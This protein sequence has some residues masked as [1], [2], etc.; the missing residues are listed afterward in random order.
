M[1]VVVDAADETRL[2]RLVDA[3]ACRSRTR[4]PGWRPRRP[5]EQRLAVAD[6]RAR[7]RRRPRRLSRRPGR[8]RRRSRSRRLAAAGRC[9]TGRRTVDRVRP[10]TDLQRRVAPFEVVS[11]FQPA[12]DQPTAI[13][14]LERRIRAGEKER[15]AARRHRHRQVRH[16]RLADRAAAAPH[17]GHGAQQDPGRPARQRVPRA[18]AQ[19]RGRVLRLLLRLLPA[20]GVRPA[21]G[22]L[23]REGLLDQRRGRA[24]AALRDQLA[25]HPPRR[26]R[27]RRRCPASTASAP[28]RSTSTAW[29]GSRSATRSTATSCCAASS[30]SSTPATTWPSPAAPSGSAA[31]P[32]RS[33]RSTRSSPSAS[34]CSATRSSGC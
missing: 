34:R 20:R 15:R 14:E 25:A 30:T 18:A 23:H 8:G 16:H 1:V 28:R 33:S 2:R 10:T 12:G 11:D 27:G 17:A 3:A 21:D 29:S 9:R 31:T 5:R 26:D 22:H 6:V 7:Q 32:S 4:G 13:D 24:A 19:Q